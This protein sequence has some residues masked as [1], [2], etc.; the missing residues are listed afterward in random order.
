MAMKLL[1][2]AFSLT[3]SAEVAA[4][5]SI[6]I[7]LMRVTT[8]TRWRR[9]F[10]ALIVINIAVTVMCLF[11]ILMSCWPVQLLWDLARQGHCNVDERTVV[12]YIQGSKV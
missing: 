11:A 7:M 12:I 10:V 6:S 3:P 5:I 8:S 2:V 4:K 9:F 1:W